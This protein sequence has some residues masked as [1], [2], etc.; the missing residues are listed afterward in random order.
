ME[1]QDCVTLSALVV[2]PEVVDINASMRH[3]IVNYYTFPIDAFIV[4]IYIIINTKFF[5]HL[6]PYVRIALCS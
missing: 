1:A 2:L 6:S 3:V 4:I 5:A